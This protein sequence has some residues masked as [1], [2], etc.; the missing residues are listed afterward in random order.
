[1]FD[2]IL[3]ILLGLCITFCIVM[4]ALYWRQQKEVINRLRK[5]DRSSSSPMWNYTNKET[6]Y[7]PEE[8]EREPKTK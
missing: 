2:S 5:L 8:N 3:F 7:M 6:F 4:V 1:M